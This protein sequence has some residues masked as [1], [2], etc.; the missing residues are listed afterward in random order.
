M[1]LLKSTTNL[2]R[3]LLFLERDDSISVLY[4]V[5]RWNIRFGKYFYHKK[6]TTVEIIDTLKELGIGKGSNIFVHSAWDTFYNYEG[7]IQELIDALI[8]LIGPEGTIA[9][10]AFPILKK[11]KV[12]NVKRTPTG[13]GMLPEMFRRYPG[14]LRS[15]NVRHSVCALGPLAEYLTKDHYKSLVSFDENSPYYRICEKH[16]TVFSLGMP[17]YYIGTYQYV[18]QATKRHEI[19]YF[20]QFYDEKRLDTIEYIDYDGGKKSYQQVYEP[21]FFHRKSYWKGKY[22][23]KRYFDKNKYRI[24]KLSNLYITA[25]D[26]N[27]ANDKFIELAKKNVFLYTYPFVKNKQKL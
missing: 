4:V 14:V 20:A 8:D 26:A 6:Y 23:V 13:A 7:N 5:K 25:V 9:M 24:C 17:P 11:G 27:Y 2:L 18:S 3:S 1:G 22:I 15:C 21:H 10:P 12:F 19:P 16:F